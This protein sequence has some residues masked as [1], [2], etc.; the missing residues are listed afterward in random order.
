MCENSQV[1]IFCKKL[2]SFL[3]PFGVQVKDWQNFRNKTKYFNMID[4]YFS[5]SKILI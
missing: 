2:R 5:D 3:K 1:K 4:L